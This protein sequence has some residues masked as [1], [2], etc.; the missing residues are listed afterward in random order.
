MNSSPKGASVR[1]VVLQPGP[2]FQIWNAGRNAGGFKV[3]VSCCEV[4]FSEMHLGLDD[5][6]LVV[7][8][9][10]SVVLA[11]EAL[12]FSGGVLVVEV[13]DG[14]A[15]CVEGGGR[16]GEESVEPYGERFGNVR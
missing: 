16:S 5:G 3:V 6:E 14:A 7:E 15:E 11:M 8:M 9:S 10:E 4:I 2:S 12:Q 13:G 1:G